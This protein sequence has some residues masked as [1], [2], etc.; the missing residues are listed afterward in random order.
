MHERVRFTIVTDQPEEAIADMLCCALTNAPKWVRIL[1]DPQDI[2]AIEDGMKCR[3]VW[4]SSGGAKACAAEW[5]WRERRMKGGIDYLDEADEARILDW[6]KRHKA[7]MVELLAGAPAQ[8]AEPHARESALSHPEPE[9]QKLVLTQ[10]W[11]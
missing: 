4:Y 10:R 8:P 2:L 5:A 7:R 6:V 3:G 11:V 9:L 1:S